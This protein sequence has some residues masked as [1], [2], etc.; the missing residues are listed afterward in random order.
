MATQLHRGKCRGQRAQRIDARRGGLLSCISSEVSTS[1]DVE[2]SQMLTTR[3]TLELAFVLS[4]ADPSNH[5]G[6]IKLTYD[7]SS[8]LSI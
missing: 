4:G 6:K 8:G 3:V 5:G 2:P 7:S 1:A